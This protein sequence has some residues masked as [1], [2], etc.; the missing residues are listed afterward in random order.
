[1]MGVVLVMLAGLLLG[2][3]AR[4]FPADKGWEKDDN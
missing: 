1:M 4:F 2:L 3:G